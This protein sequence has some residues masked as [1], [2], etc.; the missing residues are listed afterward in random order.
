MNTPLTNDLRSPLVKAIERYVAN[1][2]I[3]ADLLAGVRALEEQDDV[4]WRTRRTLVEERDRL[5][6][7]LWRIQPIL[8]PGSEIAFKVER[9]V[10]NV[11]TNRNAPAPLPALEVTK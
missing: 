3:Q 2:A 10:G 4:H 1:P 6:D 7:L 5:R 8:N 9:E 11:H